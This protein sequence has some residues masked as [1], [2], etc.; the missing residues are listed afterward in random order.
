MPRPGGSKTPFYNKKTGKMGVRDACKY[1]KTWRDAV[2]GACLEAYQGPPLTG[3]IAMTVI[4]Y[5]PRPKC[6]YGTGCNAGKLKPSA[7]Q[8]PTTRPDRTKLL[9][10]TEDALTDVGLWRDDAQVVHGLVSKR[11]SVSEQRSGVFIKVRTLAK[12][13]EEY[14]SG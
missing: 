6:H 3:P 2:R 5:M 10:S 4:F 9:R 12:T 13:I 11:Y 7:P 14:N 8:Y 1:N